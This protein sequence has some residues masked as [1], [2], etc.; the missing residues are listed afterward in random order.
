VLTVGASHRTASSA[1][2][3]DFGRAAEAFQEELRSGG[4][5]G[6]L[7]LRELAIL[8]TCARVEVY[9]VPDGS[10]ADEAARLVGRRVF[11]TD[12]SSDPASAPAYRYAGQ[13]SIR[14]VCRVA[15]GLDSF[16]LGE[17]EIGGQ[18]TRALRGGVGLGGRPTVLP[19]VATLA[20]RASAR[21]RSETA[22]GRYPASVSSVAVDIAKGWLG[23]LE[24]RRAAVVGAGWAGLLVARSLRALGIGHLT[25]VNRSLERARVVAAE[26]GAEVAGLD[27][28]PR[29]LV[30]ADVV[31][32]ATGAEGLV[33]RM[34][35]AVDALRARGDRE[36]P[37]LLID[38]ALP[39]DVHPAVS[40]LDGVELLTLDDVKVRVRRHLSLRE[41]ELGAAE[42]LV[43]EIVDD[44]VRKQEAPDVE[45]VI[46]DLR[47]SIDAVRAAEVERWL[48]DRGA[49]SVPTREEL[50]RLT[51]SIVNKLLHEPMRRMRDAPERSSESRLM[52]RAARELVVDTLRERLPGG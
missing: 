45:A 7:P 8:S 15:A 43:D 22:I 44:F 51:R 32:T 33:V 37:L 21:V 26:V 1:M 16:V 9:A 6:R 35:D 36:L 19:G 46:A 27:T 42:R 10:S 38:L 20:K 11:G 31:L 23:P 30:E 39:G 48:G 28:L 4:S 13:E 41:D 25:I 34:S 49:D 5:A 14:H 29:H 40:A 24:S 52:L 50:D 2:L 18:V 3:G 17:H 47:R 12:V